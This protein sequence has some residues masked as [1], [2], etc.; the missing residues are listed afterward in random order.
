[1][2]QAVL[3][4]VMHLWQHSYIFS[5]AC[6]FPQRGLFYDLV[7]KCYVPM[8]LL[9]LLLVLINVAQAARTVMMCLTACS[10]AGQMQLCT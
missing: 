9:I 10:T 7:V 6:A 4:A 3:D 5:S 8:W 2:E 1:M